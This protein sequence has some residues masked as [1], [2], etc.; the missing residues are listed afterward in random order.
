[1]LGLG[2]PDLVVTL[3]AYAALLRSSG[4]QAEAENLEERARVIRSKYTT[5]DSKE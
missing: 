4:R 2:H 1:M 5:A 3:E